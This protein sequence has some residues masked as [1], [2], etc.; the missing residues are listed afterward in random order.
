MWGNKSWINSWINIRNPG[1]ISLRWWANQELTNSR[2]ECPWHRDRARHVCHLPRKYW[3]SRSPRSERELWSLQLLTQLGRVVGSALV[4]WWAVEEEELEL[5]EGWRE[6]VVAP[7]T[8]QA[9]AFWAAPR[10]WKVWP[11]ELTPL[12]WWLCRSNVENC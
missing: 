3:R 7:V 1:T 10:A 8:A 2:E 4:R 11:L 5:E 6:R 12:C 9:E